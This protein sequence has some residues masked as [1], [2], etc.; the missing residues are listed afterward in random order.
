M[1]GLLGNLAGWSK[2]R[3]GASGASTRARHSTRAR[4]STISAVSI[5]LAASALVAEIASPRWRRIY[6]THLSRDCNSRAAVE[7]AFAGVRAT[8]TA[9][10]FSV[11]CP[12]ESTPFY[13]FV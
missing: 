1:G 5:A 12:G 10:E 2:L 4:N 8:L 11:V 7:A 6:L 13:E 9:C 3:A